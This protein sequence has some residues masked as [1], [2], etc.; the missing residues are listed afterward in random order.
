MLFSVIFPISN[1]HKKFTEIGLIWE[2]Q[3]IHRH[4]RKKSFRSGT[5]SLSINYL[6]T[7][8]IQPPSKYVQGMVES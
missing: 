8:E 3:G 7:H 5:H 4:V 2:V 1:D 6:I